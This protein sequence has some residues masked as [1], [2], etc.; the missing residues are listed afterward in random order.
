VARFKVGVQ[1]HPQ[2]TTVDELLEAARVADSLGVD[3]IWLW[4]HF[5]PLYA[6]DGPYD[7]P[8]APDL[9]GSHFESWTLLAALAVSVDHAMLGVL[10][11]NIHFRNPDL[12]ADMARTIDHLCNGRFIL[13]LGAGNIERDFIEYGYDFVDGRQRLEIL[14]SGIERIKRRV[15]VLDP[16]PMG[17]LPLLI[18]G[19]GRKVTLRIVAQYADLW[20]SF[21]PPAEYAAQ[22]VALGEWC[23]TLGRDPTEIERTVL[24]DT[25]AEIDELNEFIEA[26]CKHFIVGCGH[27]FDMADVRRLL[28]ARDE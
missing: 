2:H 20:N 11:S 25:G 3:G 5:F 17:T 7:W 1:L 21:G 22:N 8:P 12:M 16:P 4:D 14:E 19:S 27:P 28:E 18:G 23:E 13:G 26:G 24:M 15:S 6:K 9:T 10:I